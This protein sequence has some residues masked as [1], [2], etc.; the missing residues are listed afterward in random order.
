MSSMI[1]NP[2]KFVGRALSTEKARGKSN[3]NRRSTV[4]TVQ[5]AMTETPDGDQNTPS[6]LRERPKANTSSRARARLLNISFTTFC[7]NEKKL[8]KNVLS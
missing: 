5:V 1:G 3:D 2:K 7:R 8:Q 6:P 4:K